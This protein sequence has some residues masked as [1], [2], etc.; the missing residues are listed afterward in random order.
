VKTCCWASFK[1]QHCAMHSLAELCQCSQAPAA[2]KAPLQGLQKK[3]DG[4]AKAAAKGLAIGVPTP[5]LQQKAQQ[6]VTAPLQG[7]QKKAPAIKAPTVTAPAA[8][9][10]EAAAPLQQVSCRWLKSPRTT[11]WLK[12]DRTKLDW[13]SSAS[14]VHAMGELSA[15]AV[16]CCE[17]ADLDLPAAPSRIPNPRP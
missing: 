9:A 12:A 13:P 8:K 17:T 1:S 5:G 2:A 16:A 6:A 11:R 15:G 3:A 7:L 4:A 14:Y 10:P